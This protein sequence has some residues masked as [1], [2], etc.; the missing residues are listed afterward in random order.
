MFHL[1]FDVFC[2]VFLGKKVEDC[3]VIEEDEEQEVN[4][5]EDDDK[6][7]VATPDD[8]NDNKRPGYQIHSENKSTIKASKFVNEVKSKLAK[9]TNETVDKD[10]DDDDVEDNV[11][12]T[13]AV[14]SKESVMTRDENQQKVVDKTSKKAEVSGNVGQGN[15]LSVQEDSGQ[16]I[17]D[18]D[19]A[20]NANS[21]MNGSYN[22]LKASDGSGESV[23]ESEKGGKSGNGK[24]GKK[25]K[26]KGSKKGNDKGGKD[27]SETGEP[28][29]SK[30]EVETELSWQEV[31]RDNP[32]NVHR[33]KCAFD[34]SNAVMFD[35]DI[36]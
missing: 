9:K 20:I 34:F 8:E 19:G 17:G 22:G 3:G 7:E 6:I 1:V 21:Q 35:L 10:S 23:S 32:G 26:N 18:T 5:S 28:E 12:R 30:N 11:L 24:R 36:D 16:T 31:N 27:A 14:I 2:L 13:K 4:E 15:D 25:K 33:T 29:A